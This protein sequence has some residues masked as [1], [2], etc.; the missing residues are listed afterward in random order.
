M[1]KEEARRKWFGTIGLALPLIRSHPHH[2]TLLIHLIGP[3][4][5]ATPL[6]A[7]NFSQ[8]W[9]NSSLVSAVG[10]QTL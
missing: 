10:E 1:R 7:C 6:I 5:P 3:L 9:I 2:L 4:P 8:L